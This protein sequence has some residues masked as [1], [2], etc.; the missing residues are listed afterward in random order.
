MELPTAS[1]ANIAG[2]HGLPRGELSS[3]PR[4]L[5]TIQ[6][7]LL[8]GP[9]QGSGRERSTPVSESTAKGS[10]LPSSQILIWLNLPTYLSGGWCNSAHLT[11]EDTEIRDVH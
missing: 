3:G 4:L 1:D 10:V 6:G 9:A 7:G 5:S 11:Y 2:S 8:Q